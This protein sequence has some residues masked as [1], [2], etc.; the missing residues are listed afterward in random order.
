[1]KIWGTVSLR[2]LLFIGVINGE[3]LSKQMEQST[4]LVWQDGMIRKKLEMRI[5]N[6]ERRK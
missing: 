5:Q 2:I 1:M 4:L 6:L 3:M